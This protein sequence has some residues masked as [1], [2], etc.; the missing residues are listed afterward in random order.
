[1]TKTNEK[2]KKVLTENLHNLNRASSQSVIN[3]MYEA[4]KA[5]QIH[6][7]ADKFD[8]EKFRNYCWK[9]ADYS[10]EQVTVLGDQLKDRNTTFERNVNLAI[11]LYYTYL[12][13][14]DKFNLSFTNKIKD[15]S[16]FVVDGTYPTKTTKGKTLP[17][18]MIDV[19]TEAINNFAESIL[20]KNLVSKGNINYQELNTKFNDNI[21]EKLETHKNFVSLLIQAYRSSVIAYNKSKGDGKEIEFIPE[22]RVLTTQMQEFKQYTPKYLFEVKAK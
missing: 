14:G 6:N 20:S 17:P 4:M 7:K 3:E 13:K 16:G 15:V 12:H 18:E 22:S 10:G 8:K 9:L 11:D 5:D 19:V 1:M 2:L 21:V